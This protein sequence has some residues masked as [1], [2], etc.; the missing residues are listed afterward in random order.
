MPSG[1]KIR[2]IKYLI[3]SIYVYKMFITHKN[4]PSSCPSAASLRSASSRLI[5]PWNHGICVWRSLATMTIRWS[6]WAPRAVSIRTFYPHTK[7]QHF[8]KIQRILQFLSSCKSYTFGKGKDKVNKYIIWWMVRN[9]WYY[10][11]YCTWITPFCTEMYSPKTSSNASLIF[12]NGWILHCIYWKLTCPA[13]DLSF[14]IEC[15]DVC[16]NIHVWSPEIIPYHSV[17]SDYKTFQN[18]ST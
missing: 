2:I 3:L 5:L 16:S 18:D 4:F 13:I 14:M 10:L 12:D 7:Q 11:N 9:S 6:L 1:P 15:Y 8:I 17:N